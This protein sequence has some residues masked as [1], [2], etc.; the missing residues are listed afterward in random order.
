VSFP[1]RGINLEGIAE[2]D[3]CFIQLLCFHIPHAVIEMLVL[4]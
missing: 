2:L 3:G 1:I 4:S